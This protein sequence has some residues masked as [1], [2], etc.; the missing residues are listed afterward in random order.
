MSHILKFIIKT[1]KYLRHFSFRKI[2]YIFGTKIRKCKCC[3]KISVFISL[4]KGEEAKRCIRCLANLRYEMLSECIK[5]NYGGRLRGFDVLELDVN[6]P[7]QSLLQGSRTYVM[8]YYSR[9]DKPGQLKDGIRCE[10]ITRLTFG[11]DQFDLIVSSDVLEHVCDLKRAFSESAR[12][13]KPNG[14]HLFTVPCRSEGDTFQRS[15][16]INGVLEHRAAPQ[17]HYDPLNASGCLTYWTFGK[18]ICE[19]FKGDNYMI[20]IIEGPVGYDGRYLF[21]LKKFERQ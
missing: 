9:S 8:T 16:W 1:A 7:L 13:L 21:E 19:V 2:F 18:D 6:S 11:A 14:V 5:K 3:G 15:C 20:S 12:V 4:D 10:D 17:Y